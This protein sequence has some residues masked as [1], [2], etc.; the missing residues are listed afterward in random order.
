MPVPMLKERAGAQ[1]L[2]ARGE[3]A[4]QAVHQFR[5]ADE[6]QQESRAQ[7][8]GAGELAAGSLEAVQI[9]RGDRAGFAQQPGNHVGFQRVGLFQRKGDAFARAGVQIAG[10]VA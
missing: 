1:L 7:V 6:K 2:W 9:A 3:L 10:G 5:P 4:D 8:V